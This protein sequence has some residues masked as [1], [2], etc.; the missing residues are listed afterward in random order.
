[1]CFLAL[2]RGQIYHLNE[3]HQGYQ[4]TYLEEFFNLKYAA[5]R[6]VIERYF[7]L[8]KKR[9]GL[10]FYP[11]R[12]HNRII[13]ACCFLHNFI[14]REMSVD[15]IEDLVGEYLDANPLVHNDQIGRAH[16]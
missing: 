3:W 8:L 12:V 1:M 15:P 6:N 14:R 9:C 5:A 11:I 7:G 4:P 10:S 13:V 2:F 16:V